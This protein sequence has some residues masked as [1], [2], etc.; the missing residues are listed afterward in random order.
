MMSDGY[1]KGRSPTKR[2]T[3]VWPDGLFEGADAIRLL[4]ESFD[5]GETLEADEIQAISSVVT[6]PGVFLMYALFGWQLSLLPTNEPALWV[7][8]GG[9]CA[10]LGIR[11]ARWA[12]AARTC[13]AEA[14]GLRFDDVAVPWSTVER[15]Q[16]I[17]DAPGFYLVLDTGGGRRWTLLLAS[18]RLLSRRF[19][20]RWSGPPAHL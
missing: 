3:A 7:L 18:T 8:V 4:E 17:R 15:V 14:D 13:V 6:V 5:V 2:R 11:G 20:V 12:R 19:G 10:L 9:A 1:G 16:V